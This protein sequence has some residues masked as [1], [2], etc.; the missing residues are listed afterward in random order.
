MFYSIRF[1][2][3]LLYSGILCLILTGFSAYLFQTVRHTLYKNV[4]DD[5]R[6]KAQQINGIIDAYAEMDR[7]GL[8]SVALMRQFLT[9]RGEVTSGRDIIDELWEK[10]S[11]SLGLAGDRFRIINLNGQIVLRSKNMDRLTERT[12]D[13]D[14]KTCGRKTCFVATRINNVSF[15]SVNYPFRFSNRSEFVLQLTTPLAAVE[16]V[17][18]R[19]LLFMAGGVVFILLITVFIGA[20]LTRRILQP[21]LEVIRTANNISQKNLGVRIVDRARDGEMGLLVDSFNRMIERL[22]KSFTHINEF[23]SE[24]AHEL[25]T[26]LAIIKGELELALTA[27]GIKEEDARMLGS[28]IQEVDRLTKIITD[29][30][31]L[32]R[33]EYRQ[34]VFKMESFDLYAFLKALCERVRVLSSEKGIRLDVM[35]PDGELF[36]QGDAGHLR[37]VF[38]NLAHNAVKFTPAG[39]V[40]RLSADVDGG[41]ARV[42]VSD[43]G[44]GIAPADQAKVFEKFFRVRKAREQDPAGTGL[45]LALA[46]SIVK[47]HHGEIILQS[48]LNLGS[49]F[50][51]F[52]PL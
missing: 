3:S 27:P 25:K 23:S 4:E 12:F 36:I 24:V 16:N 47:A 15:E 34:D 40:I 19:L 35:V 38:F 29:L 51:V 5:L 7:S 28:T 48:E 31:L 41:R 17:L 9:Q 26:P 11:R 45:G 30:L 43:T 42:T 32:A 22:E 10:D 14:F 44:E 18:S 50:I 21:V 39:G 13:R 37:R 20:F 2:A 33:F 8:S 52:L 6:V 46:L 49:S 1:R